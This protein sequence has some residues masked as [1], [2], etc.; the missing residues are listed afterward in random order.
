MSR[1]VSFSNLLE[2][3]FPTYN[4]NHLKI[5]SI[6]NSFNSRERAKRILLTMLLVAQILKAS[7]EEYYYFM[8]K[9]ESDIF[10]EIDFSQLR[11]F[12]Q[13]KDK[14]GSQNISKK[15]LKK[16]L[17]EIKEVFTKEIEL[18]ND[19]DRLILFKEF[20]IKENGIKGLFNGEFIYLLNCHSNNK[21]KEWY[22]S[23][24]GEYIQQG[25]TLYTVVNSTINE[26]ILFS[27]VKI[28]DYNLYGIP[29]IWKKLQK[30]MFCNYSPNTPEPKKKQKLKEVL[31][32]LNEK[33]ELEGEGEGLELEITIKVIGGKS[34][35]NEV[36]PYI[37]R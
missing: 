33:L 27:I 4:E 36:L 19:K 21:T 10:F 34:Y 26:L 28:R 32:G 3:T 14:Y 25:I 16:S 8:N 5:L 1:L 37:K 2:K 30:Y 12:F 13:S 29:S 15:D 23:R 17:E 22:D 18:S 31:K 7:E 6:L 35:I 9:K 20:E 11:D 24:V